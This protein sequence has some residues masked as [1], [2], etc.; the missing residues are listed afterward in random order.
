MH[1]SSQARPAEP[2]REAGLPKAEQSRRTRELIIETGIRCL[3]K[4]GYLQTSMHLISKEANISRG[5]LHYHFKDKNDLMSAIAERLPR[6]IDP[7]TA[8]RLAAATS[9]RDKVTTLVAI[10]IEQHLG[11]HHVIA[12]DLLSAARRDPDL[13]QAIIP[14]L[15]A[16]EQAIDAW[17]LSFGAEL[18]WSAD[19]MRA[20]RTVF[21]A[22]LRG[23][24][25][26]Y[27]IQTDKQHHEQAAKLLEQMLLD[28]LLPGRAA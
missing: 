16:S 25:L 20:F 27:A 6:R 17:W 19:R 10:G 5:P 24:A 23:L 22:A 1:K 4:F 15:S 13:A 28:F 3:A 7:A 9:I 2:V 8:R 21:V 12:V 14:H 11:D 26:D 18:G